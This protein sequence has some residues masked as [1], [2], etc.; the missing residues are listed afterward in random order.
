MKGYK[1]NTKKIN[2]IKIQKYRKKQIK[3]SSNIVKRIKES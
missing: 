2:N 1:D 3:I